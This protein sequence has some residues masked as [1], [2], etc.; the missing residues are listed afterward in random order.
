LGGG[1]NKIKMVSFAALT[2]TVRAVSK[3]VVVVGI[4]F[5]SVRIGHAAH[6]LIKDKK[7]PTSEE[8]AKQIEELK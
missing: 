7:C 3:V 8:I 6:H 4:I 5:D 2:I 1:E